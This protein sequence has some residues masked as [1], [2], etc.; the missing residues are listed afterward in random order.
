MSTGNRGRIL[1]VA[2][3]ALAL[4]GCQSGGVQQALNLGSSKNSAE[5]QR[6][7]I[8]EQ[9][10]RGYCPQV[11]LRENTGYYTTY[12]KGSDNDPDAAIYQAAISK[13]TRSCNQS[14]GILHMKIAAAGRVVAGPKGKNGTISMP[15]RVAVLEGDNVLYSQLTRHEVQIDTSAGATQFLVTD[16]NVQVPIQPG[17]AFRVYVGY[18]EGPYNTP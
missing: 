9:Q 1:A 4:A 2:G 5:Q 10:L 6:E 7:Q 14:D 18:D 3:L 13:V 12:E 16:D 8:T 11:T 15:I 17:S